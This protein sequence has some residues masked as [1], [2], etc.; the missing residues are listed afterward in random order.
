MLDRP[1]EILRWPAAVDKAQ[2]LLIVAVDTPETPIREAARRR[3][4]GVLGEILGDV[5]FISVPGQPIRLAGLDSTLGIS[6]SHEIG[7]SLLAIHFS[8]PVG[9]DLLKV[10]DSPDWQ[11][12][13]PILSADYL[14]PQTA[15]RI[16]ELAP[17]ARM[18]QFSHAWTEQE[19]RLK[20]RGYGLEEWSEALEKELSSCRVR[21]LALPA[22]YVGAAVTLKAGGSRAF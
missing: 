14:G 5:G 17:S 3:V 20:C 8:G 6:V 19:A 10:A 9:I 15:Q 18:M 13:I 12:E 1:L 22:G 2:D 4:R 7:L 11:T 21:Q 16:A